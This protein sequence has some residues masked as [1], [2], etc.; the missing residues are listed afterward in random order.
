MT[1][2]AYNSAAT[3]LIEL[4]SFY[5]NYRFNSEISKFRELT[6]VVSRVKVQVEHLQD[7]HETL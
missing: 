3:E 2:I 4:S 6:A 7:L 5:I 1:Q